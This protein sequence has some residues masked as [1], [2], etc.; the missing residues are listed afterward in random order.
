[1][2]RESATQFQLLFENNPHPMWI[3]DLETLHFL[4]VN[5]AAIQHYGYSGEEFLAMTLK[6]ISPPEDIP[7]LLESISRPTHG[8]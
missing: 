7:G 2:L 8:V 3:T 4:A 6:D 1:M 5:D